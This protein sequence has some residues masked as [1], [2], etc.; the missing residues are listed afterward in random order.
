MTE[1]SWTPTILRQI[2][3]LKRKHY[4]LELLY[5]ALDAIS[6]NDQAKLRQLHDHGLQGNHQG[7][8]ELHIDGRDWLLIYRVDQGRTKILLLATGSHKKLLGK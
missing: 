4:N 7:D 2:K 6:V 3:V 5:V 8:R 1:L